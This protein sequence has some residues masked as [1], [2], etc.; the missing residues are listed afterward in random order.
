[1]YR[2][3]VE[4]TYSEARATVPL[5]EAAQSRAVELAREGDAV[6]QALLPWLREHIVEETDHDRWL[7]VDYARIGG[8]PATMA[9]WPGCPTVAAMVGS[10]Y[11]W[12]LHAHPVAILGYCAVLEGTPPS[13][14]FVVVSAGGLER[15]AVSAFA[16]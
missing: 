2:A 15:S 6:A 7:L 11:Y 16:E 13:S 9:D 3:L 8:D 14:L 4:L 1:M 5:M 12:A 10:V